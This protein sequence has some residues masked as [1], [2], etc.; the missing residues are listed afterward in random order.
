MAKY[1]INREFFPFYLFS[2]PIQDPETAGHLGAMMQPP[3]RLWR[4]PALHVR[5]QQLLGYRGGSFE[6]LIITPTAHPH[7]ENCLV[8]FHGGGFT[9]GGAPYHYQN[10]RDYAISTPCKVVFVR[11]RLAPAHPFPYPTEDCYEA[12]CWVRNNAKSLGIDPQRIG[13][14]GDSAGGCLAAAVSQ[15]AR[16]RLGWTLGFQMLIYPFTNR[17]L[18]SPSNLRFTDT[19]M[20]NSKLS[21]QMLKGYL[22]DPHA[23]PIQYA[24]PI[25]A[26]CFAD[27]P[28]AY[29][30]TAEFDCLHDDGIAYAEKLT[31]A[32]VEVTLVETKGTMHGF[33][34]VR[35]APTTK[36]VIG[37]R[38]QFLK[39]RFA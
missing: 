18:T 28:T 27:L 30:E 37:H 26:E 19:P 36:Q 14:G 11:Y 10:A 23:G 38:I 21:Q 12:L 35:W 25:E 34:I 15:M 20:W 2:N 4:D 9:F 17:H 13:V 8:Y 24:S 31:E 22:P 1:P 7:T 32:R 16:D 33:D 39:D 29:I 5:K 6:V 3:S